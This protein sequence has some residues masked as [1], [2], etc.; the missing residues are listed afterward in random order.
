[1]FFMD[2][3]VVARLTREEWTKGEKFPMLIFPSRLI[4]EVSE[5]GDSARDG[6]IVHLFESLELPFHSTR[7]DAFLHAKQIADEVGY[8]VYKHDTDKLEVMGTFADPHLLITYDEQARHMADVIPLDRFN[9]P[10]RPPLLTPEIRATLPKLYS[11]EQAGLETSAQVKFVSP[12]SGWV[13]YASEFDGSEI[14][15]G[16]VIG[17]EIELGYFTLEELTHTRGPLGLKIERDL[18]FVPQPLATLR[19]QHRKARGEQP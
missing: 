9:L 1:L 7:D 14:F 11:G 15:F 4:F 3:D 17:Y 8:R 6:C 16:L 19:A 5:S 12:D 2:G 18:D 13:W 10:P